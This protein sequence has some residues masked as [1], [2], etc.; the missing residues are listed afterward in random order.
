MGENNTRR[1]QQTT[2]TETHPR[3]GRYNFGGALYAGYCVL[4]TRDLIKL[5]NKDY[6]QMMG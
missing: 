3:G 2:T 4:I 5:K 6:R 1:R